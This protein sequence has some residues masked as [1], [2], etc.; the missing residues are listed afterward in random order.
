LT[1][2]QL[3]ARR[4][5]SPDQIPGLSTLPDN[6]AAVPVNLTPMLAWRGVVRANVGAFTGA[7]DDLSELLDRMQRGLHDFSN[8]S[9]HAVLG[10]T[11]WFAGNWTMARV[12]LRLAAEIA[13]DY[14]PSLV[15]VCTP[16]VAI[17]QGDFARADEEIAHARDLLDRAPW[18]EACDQLAMVEVIRRHAEG[19]M[20]S[21][22]YQDVR[23]GIAA[24]RAGATRKT[25]M[26]NIHAGLAAVWAGALEDAFVCAGVLDSAAAWTEWSAGLAEWLRGL[27]SEAAGDGKSALVHLRAAAA[28]NPTA[29]PLYAA[30]IHADHARIAHLMG[31]GATAARSLDIAAAIYERL[32]AAPYLHRI[33]TLRSSSAGEKTNT[34][35]LSE[36][37]HDVL[38]HV[39]AGM[40]YKQIARDLFITQSTVSYHLGNIYAKAD[41]TSRHQ[42]TQLVRQDPRAFGLAVQA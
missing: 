20:P 5:D 24:I 12:H 39:T 33:A 10:R 6:P 8:G 16:V 40:S 13:G 32:G 21:E 23:D 19:T 7:I 41:V 36:R 34:F 2:A 3:I 37:E 29:I 28:Q 15:Q 27:A 22:P 31:D 42:L 17:G 35:R 14:P 11:E 25:V 1:T 38:T 18:L 30:H 26:W 4:A 9:Y